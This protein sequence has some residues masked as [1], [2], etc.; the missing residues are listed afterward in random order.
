MICKEELKHLEMTLITNG[1]LYILLT[2][3]LNL[4]LT[5][6]FILLKLTLTILKYG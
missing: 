5:L 1:I 3:T 6:I 4:K 2:R